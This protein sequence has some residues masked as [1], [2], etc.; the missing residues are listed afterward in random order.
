M[1]WSFESYEVGIQIDCDLI[2]NYSPLFHSPCS[3]GVSM[4]ANIMKKV[5]HYAEHSK[6]EHYETTRAKQ[7]EVL[8]VMC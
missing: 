5:N 7:Y 1:R 2:V 6:P 3:F 4:S 8:D